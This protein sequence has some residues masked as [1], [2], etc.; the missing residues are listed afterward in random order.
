[1]D[2]DAAG[3]AAAEEGGR[4]NHG[5]KNTMSEVKDDLAVVREKTEGMRAMI[6][7]FQI[8]DEKDLELVAEKIKQVKT[9]LKF[10]EQE[11]KKLTDPAKAIVKEAGEKYDPFIKE[12]QNAE[13]TLKHRAKTFMVAQAEA[14]A[15][16][17][18]KIAAK[19]EAGTMKPETAVKKM[20][21]LPEAKKTVTAESGAGLR[22]SKRKVAKFDVEEQK[23]MLSLVMGTIG[24]DT[25]ANMIPAEY[26]IID[27]VRV[28][29]EALAREKEG[30]E[31]ITGVKV[32]EEN[33]IASV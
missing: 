20:E 3:R 15:A 33:D 2:A 18:A 8:K 26:W 17:Q 5:T 16:K 21:A 27:E 22:L 23:K 31:Q 25:A 12:C 13:E 1:M 19:V 4:I 29:K 7:G 30:E 10:V 6:E 9:M 14:T 28:R 32:V 24:G 11:K